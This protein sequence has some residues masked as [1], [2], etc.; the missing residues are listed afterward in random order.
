METLRIWNDC[1]SCSKRLNT[2]LLIK[3]LVFNLVTKSRKIPDSVLAVS[4]DY[5]QRACAASL[6]TNPRLLKTLSKDSV[7]YVVA[8]CAENENNYISTLKELMKSSDYSINVAAE[9]ALLH[10][11]GLIGN[12]LAR[13]GASKREIKA[14]NEEKE[15]YLTYRT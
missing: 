9:S 8:K 4:S 12:S 11:I 14:L 3:K 1:I 15:L 10:K 2:A 6:S 5:M 13:H 7:K